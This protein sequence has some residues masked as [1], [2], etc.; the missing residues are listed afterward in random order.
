MRAPG[1]LVA[2]LTAGLISAT[3]VAQD[4]PSPTQGVVK[5]GKVP[6]SREVLKVKLPK[7]MEADLPNGAHLIVLEDHRLPQISFQIFVPGAGGYADPAD[8][9]GLAS[10]VA[11]MMRE[12][13]ATRTSEQISQQLEV[14]AATLNVTAG[15][16]SPEA[17][18]SGSCLTDQFEG[19]VDITADV[20]LHP[21]FPAQEIARYQQAP[22]PACRNNGPIRGSSPP[23]CSRGVSTA[24]IRPRDSRRR[25][26][27]ST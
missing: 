7:P 11:A 13:T 25:L 24:R 15:M 4:Q 2:T 3:G 5:K 22:A 14:M 12:G 1:L 8:Q 10:F 9:P 16:A 26:P 19:L 27:R 20:L 17:T 18:I 6:V 23:K 21:S